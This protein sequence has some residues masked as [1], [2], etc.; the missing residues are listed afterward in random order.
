MPLAKIIDYRLLYKASTLYYEKGLMQ[1]EISDRLSISR[2]KVS[3]LLK[4]AE[5]V[6][7]VKH[8]ITPLGG[9]N[10]DIEDKLETRFGLVEAVVVDVSEPD[11][12]KAILREIGAAAA[13]LFH[14]VISNPSIIGISWGQA[15]RE[16]VDNLL[17]HDLS[18]SEL[19]QLNG[20][21][22]TPESETHATY[23]LRKAVDQLN[24]KLSILNIPGLVDTT[25]AKNIMLSDSHVKDVFEL[26]SKIDHA[27]VG[28]GD[29]ENSI[30][31]VDQKL[32]SFEDIE[33]LRLKGAVGE[34]ALRFFDF[35]GAPV[36]S[37]IDERVIGI[38]LDELKK[39]PYIT[40]IAGGHRK[41]EPIIAALNGNLINVLVTDRN[42]AIAILDET[43]YPL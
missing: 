31:T 26:F 23:I 15:L 41:I 3:R 19:V 42:T 4:Q 22:G 5:E 11:S 12:E 34:I 1:S 10:T 36:P 21:V 27:F 18:N 2:T 38:T 35:E 40:A 32:V 16:M 33:R 28:I 37:S 39:I 20:G 17:I 7:I 30:L 43:E 8:V 24:C 14:R 9:V 29:L 6:G 13:F 25:K